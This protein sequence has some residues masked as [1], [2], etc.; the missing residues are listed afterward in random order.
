MIAESTAFSIS[1]GLRVSDSACMASASGTG[2]GF[3]AGSWTAL[4]LAD[5]E[6]LRSWP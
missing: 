2:T 1:A 6:A 4:H 5:I 3:G